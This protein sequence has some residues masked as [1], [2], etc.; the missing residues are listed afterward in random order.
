MQ[1]GTV[2]ALGGGAV[3]AEKLA[4]T[5]S[6]SGAAEGSAFA[7]FSEIL[8][9]GEKAA[10][11]AINGQVPMSEAINKVLESE[12]MLTTVIAARDKFVNA[13]LELTRM[14]I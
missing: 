5:Q 7:Q 8:N 13:Y 4:P 2:Q 6:L 10:V 9:A 12:R 3:T 14:Q 11:G 1:I